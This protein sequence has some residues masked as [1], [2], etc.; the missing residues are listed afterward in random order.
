MTDEV[1]A[2]HPQT[3]PSQVKSEYLPDIMPTARGG[4]RHFVEWRIGGA[5]LKFLE[6]ELEAFSSKISAK[7]D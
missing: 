4:L 2:R 6:T 3:I 5:D 1:L 7:F